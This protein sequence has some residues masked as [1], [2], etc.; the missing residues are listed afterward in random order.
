MMMPYIEAPL[1]EPMP[2]HPNATPS[3]RLEYQRQ[4]QIYQQELRDRNDRMNWHLA[5]HIVL[6]AVIMIGSAIAI[7]A[8]V[9]AAAGFRGLAIAIAAPLVFWLA[10]AEVKRRL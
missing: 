3:E 9:Y 4:M 7:G 5:A 6:L 1:I 10:V 2:L 8:L